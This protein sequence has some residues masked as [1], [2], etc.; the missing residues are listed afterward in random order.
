MCQRCLVAK[1]GQRPAL[2]G[3]NRDVCNFYRTERVVDDL[4]IGRGGNGAVSADSDGQ[5]GGHGNAHF[6]GRGITADGAVSG[7]GQGDGRS[8]GAA[9]SV[10]GVGSRSGNGEGRE[11]ADGEDEGYDF[12][13]VFHCNYSFIN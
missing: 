10:N 13:S 8:A 7:T 1:R 2:R 3:L 6:G 12:L 11:H 4:C 5:H 9:R